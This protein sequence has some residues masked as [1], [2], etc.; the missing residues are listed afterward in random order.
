MA[1]VGRQAIPVGMRL[2]L[3]TLSLRAGAGPLR[4]RSLTRTH[5]VTGTKI[6]TRC[7][8]GANSDS[9]WTAGAL[10]FLSCYT[11]TNDGFGHRVEGWGRPAPL[12]G[13]LLLCIFPLLRAIVD[14]LWLCLPD[15][16]LQNYSTRGKTVRLQRQYFHFTSQY[17]LVGFS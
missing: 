2:T 4:R 8:R 14:N 6:G 11:N 3:D 7:A 9:R 17:R 1:P 10:V 12:L 5:T 15:M 16:G 13:Y